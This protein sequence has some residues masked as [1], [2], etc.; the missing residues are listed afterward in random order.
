M[1]FRITEILDKL[2]MR[3]EKKNYDL[4]QVYSKYDFNKDK[5]LDIY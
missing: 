1:W 5:L 2:R 4:Y 3:L